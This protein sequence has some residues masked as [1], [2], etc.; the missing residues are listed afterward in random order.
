MNKVIVS[1][2]EPDDVDDEVDAAIYTT[3]VI[4]KIEDTLLFETL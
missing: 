1:K 4:D 2:S 3:V